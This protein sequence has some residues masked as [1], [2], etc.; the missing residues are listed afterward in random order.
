[1]QRLS[2]TVLVVGG[3]ATGIGTLR[4]LSM[5]GISAILVEQG[6]LAHGTSSRFHGLLHSGARYAVNDVV[7]A[8]ECI[9]ENTI[10]KKI[11]HQC[12]EQTEGF[13]V[14]LPEDDESYIGSWADACTAAG[15]QTDEVDVNEAC[16]IEPELSKKAVR[17]FRVPDSCV[18]GFR[19]VVHNAMSA[20]RHG[21]RILQ[22]H[23]LVSIHQEQ[24]NI[25]GA[26]VE[27]TRDGSRLEIDCSAI[28]SAAG[29][30][31]GEVCSK[32]GLDVP[33]S[34][35][36]GTLLVF[37][38]RFT[39]RVVNRLHPGSDGDI[40]VPHGSI[41]I[42]GTTSVPTSRP[43]DTAPTEEEVLRLLDIGEPL[44]PNLR[45]YRI[46]RAFAG[47]RPL[48]TPKG[49]ATGRGASR[50]FQVF[51]HA[52]DGLSGF[53]SIFG[54]KLT[55]Y[56]LM[57][58]RVTDACA[59]YLGISAP[60]TTHLEPLVPD[61]DPDVL[62]K[63]ARYFPVSDLSLLADRAGDDLIPILNLAEA[64]ASEGEGANPLLCDC[65]MVSLAEVEHVA[66]ADDTYSLTDIRLRTRLGMGT[67]QGT[68][69][70]V[71]AINAMYEHDLLPAKDPLLSI[72][73]FLD[74]RF[75]GIR[76]TF[77]GTQAQ[78]MELSHAIYAG[79]LNL[80]TAL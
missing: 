62:A 36:R 51:D 47:T 40:F 67:C 74:E 9:E 53:F 59:A 29:S 24:G 37:N 57:A 5:R 72:R 69:C 31:A 35:D 19:L 63:A 10:L 27:N 56:R 39:S 21:G 46:L 41:T 70:T 42:L 23:R 45:T 76:T 7:S 3:G 77:W 25:T 18:D 34:P 78:E 65:E 17:V 28:I 32:A 38:H 48:Y 52:K 6:S 71:R 66:R 44:F 1:M 50:N 26:T 60:C 33:V 30:W 13:F 64:C 20:K 22:Y 80:D 54:G 73:D 79:V 49:T 58:E 11:G 16:S 61:P 12:I 55:T 68:F 75:R 2:T 15:I 8:R 4:D 43:D 14:A